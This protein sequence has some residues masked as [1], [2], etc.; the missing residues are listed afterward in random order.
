ML[1]GWAD[2][3]EVIHDDQLDPVLADSPS[4]GCRYGG[5]REPGNAVEDVK[6]GLG[7]GHVVGGYLGELPLIELPE[8]ERLHGD[9]APGRGH[10][11]HEAGWGH[12]EGDEQ[13]GHLSTDAGVLEAGEGNGRFAAA[14]SGGAHGSLQVGDALRG[15]LL[16][17]QGFDL[18]RFVPGQD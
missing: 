17:S 18:G 5:H 16:P 4:D 7:A 9:L 14:G 10:A 6:R 15:S 12:L 2:L 8:P 1:R 11:A 3:L 13:A